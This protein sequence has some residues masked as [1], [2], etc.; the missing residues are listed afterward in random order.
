MKAFHC[1]RW[2]GPEALVF[3][4][5]MLQPA[6]ADQIRVDVLAADMGYQDLLIL[7]GQYMVKPALPFSPG[8][9]VAGIVSETGTTQRHAVG[10]RV[11]A[12]LPYGG[13][14]ETVL[15]PAEA[16]VPLPD[17]VEFDEA[18][19][20]GIAHATAYQ[21]LVDAAELRPGEVLLVRGASGGVGRAA[22]EI[23]RALGAAVIA[24]ASSP[25][26]LQSAAA[27]GAQYLVDI[28]AENL[29][30]RTMELTGG[31]GADVILDTVG[32]DFREACLRSI[33]R[34][35]RILIVGFAGGEIPQIPAH[36]ILNKYCS[37]RGVAWGFS[38]FEREPKDYIRILSSVL[39]L[40]KSGQIA[41]PLINTVPPEGVVTA[42]QAL[43][44]RSSIGRSVIDFRRQ[45][46]ESP[47]R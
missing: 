18:A 25:E 45:I 12:L 8:N 26:K 24:A 29:R 15:V 47:A 19:A 13:Y 31:R 37:V 27:A 2:G 35:G 41:R 42:L 34:K 20:F 1:H 14:S 17:T 9:V 33:A 11:L 36:Y 22:I 16:A 6:A 23:G 28:Q 30:D 43:Q 38:V 4:N 7:A 39:E 5:I 10:D 3:E 44:S 21:A 40:R 46:P 32:S